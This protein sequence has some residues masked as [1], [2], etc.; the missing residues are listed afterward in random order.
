MKEKMNVKENEKVVPGQ[1]L[2]TGEKFI[3]SSMCIRIDDNIISTVVGNVTI[4]DNVIKVISNNNNYTPAIGDKIIGKVISMNNYGWKVN[5]GKSIVELDLR[6]AINPVVTAISG[7]F[8]SL[9]SGAVFVEM[10][11]NWDGIGLVL[12]NALKNDDLPVVMGITLIISIIFVVINLIVDVL[13]SII[14]PRVVLK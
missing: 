11:F 7:W 4:K 12:V 2:A 1:I 9:L 6:N 10:I 8:A 5:I 13:Y 14:D 3:P